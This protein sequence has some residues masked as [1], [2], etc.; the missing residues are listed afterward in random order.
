[1]NNIGEKWVFLVRRES[2]RVMKNV[3]KNKS[4]AFICLFSVDGNVTVYTLCTFNAVIT[5]QGGAFF[6]IEH[7]AAAP[8]TWTFFFQH[9]LQPVWYYFVD[10]CHITRETWKDLEVAGFSDVKLRHIQANFFALVKPHIIG[11]SV[12]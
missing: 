12:K 1:M 2:F 11:Y 3:S 8:S 9:V 5:L 10:R 7:V 6:F 4:V